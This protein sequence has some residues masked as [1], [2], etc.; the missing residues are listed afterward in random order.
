MLAVRFS[1][2]TA[3]KILIPKD[4]NLARRLGYIIVNELNKG[5]R[6]R[7]YRHNMRYF[8]YHNDPEHYAIVIASEEVL[9][10]LHV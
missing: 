8:V 7:Q 6:V 1:K 3:F 9:A 5:L 2:E 4:Q 10:G